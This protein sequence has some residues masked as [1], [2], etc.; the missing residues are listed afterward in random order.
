M[1]DWTVDS[2]VVAKWVLAE[3]DSPQA[4][5][6][7][8]D[9]AAAGGRLHA[10]DLAFV[11]ATNVIWTRYHRRLL[12]LP[13]ARQAQTLLHQAQVETAPC[14]PLLSQ[15]F[16]IA[17]QFDIAVY[18]ALFVALTRHLAIRGVTADEPLVRA[19]GSA[20]PEIK[21]LRNW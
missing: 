2:N 7:V 15:A 4:L 14:L 9:T 19:V 12:T 6:V 11:E 16:D 21:L 10:L 18:D 3:P 17:L 13:E 5:Q 20:Y 8:T 1:N